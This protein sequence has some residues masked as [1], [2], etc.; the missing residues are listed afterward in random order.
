MDGRQ[1][2]DYLFWRVDDALRFSPGLSRSSINQTIME[3]VQMNSVIA[4]PVLPGRLNFFDC[5]RKKKT[6][7]T[8][9]FLSHWW[10]FGPTWDGR[11]KVKCWGK[12]RERA[13]VL[14]QVA[15]LYIVSPSLDM[16]PVRVASYTN[17]RG[18]TK[19]FSEMQSLKG[20]CIWY[21]ISKPQIQLSVCQKVY[22]PVE[23]IDGRLSCVFVQQLW[24]ELNKLNKIL[25]Y[26]AAVS[27]W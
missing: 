8:K 21:A 6:S 18:V 11:E 5:C 25:V 17:L 4:R 27:C 24:I 3:D 20:D 2:L 12:R 26:V 1:L 9:S 22:D 14:H 10:G 7:F 16:Q 15:R 23:D 19:R 13:Q